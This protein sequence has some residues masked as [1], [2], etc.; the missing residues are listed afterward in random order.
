MQDLGQLLIGVAFVWG[1]AWV[2]GAIVTA[3]R[4]RAETRQRA[5]LYNRLMDKFGSSTE[6]LDYL[7]SE[8]GQ[9]FIDELTAKAESPIYKI[10]NS[11]QKGIILTLTGGGFLIMINLFSAS[12]PQDA[13]TALAVLGTAALL[14]GIG[15]LAA[16][17]VTYLL[18]KAWGILTIK[19][20]SEKAAA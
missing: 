6:F 4:R 19:R 13:F 14:I 15:F 11:I 16:S 2:I 1:T 7:Q 20:P 8:P 12:L 18:S 10:L 9:K 17:A 5:D 3:W